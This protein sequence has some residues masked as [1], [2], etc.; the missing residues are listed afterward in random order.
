MFRVMD[1]EDYFAPFQN[2]IEGQIGLVSDDSYLFSCLM[3][4]WV[5]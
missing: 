5:W 2:E 3:A 4:L 1:L